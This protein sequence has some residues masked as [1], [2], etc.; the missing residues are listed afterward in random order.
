MIA[1]PVTF[2]VAALVSFAVIGIPKLFTTIF[3]NVHRYENIARELVRGSA[4]R[5]E[6]DIRKI[7]EKEWRENPDSK[8]KEA[9]EEI[10]QNSEK[11]EIE[12]L[13][14]TLKKDLKE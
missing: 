13:R 1:I 14:K 10:L 7:Y 2:V 9:Y 3:F 4:T 8:W 11:E 6:T 12:E 5:H